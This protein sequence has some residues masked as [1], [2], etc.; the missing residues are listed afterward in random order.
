MEIFK[1]GLEDLNS[2]VIVLVFHGFE[3]YKILGD[4]NIPL[5]DLENNKVQL[6]DKIRIQSLV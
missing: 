2:E 3:N 4:L 5:F 6:G 1:V